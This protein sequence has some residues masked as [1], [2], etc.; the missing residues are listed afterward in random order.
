MHPEIQIERH[1]A[2]AEVI[3]NRPD[4][5]NGINWGVFKGLVEAGKALADDRALRAVILRGNGPSFCAGLDVK[6]VVGDVAHSVQG[7]IQPSGGGANIFQDCALV[8]RRLRVPV[9][10]QIHGN[11]F[12]GGMQIALGADFR[13]ATPDARFSIMEVKYGLVP[14]MG[15]TVTLSELMPID[16]AKAL[17]MSGRVFDAEEA[18][19]H[20]LLTGVA[21]DPAEPIQAMIGEMLNRSP[22]AVGAT[23]ALFQSNWKAPE[24]AA[25]REERSMQRKMFLSRNQKVAM[26]A[27]AKVGEKAADIDWKPRGEI[28][29]KP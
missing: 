23:K 27:A 5:H 15:G 25:L 1:G 9:F 2:V 10:A 19:S 13:Y 28:A 8:W 24:R 29:L 26:K 20:H 17:A 3:L 12:G 16:V 21:E 6:S 7:F 4:K 11:C 18:L 22:D 14:D